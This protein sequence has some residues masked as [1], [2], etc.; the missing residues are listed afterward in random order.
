MEPF[1]EVAA[2]DRLVHEPARLAILSTLW[3]CDSADFLFV[4]RLTGLTKGNLSNHLARL[5]EA[6]LLDIDKKF[7]S[8]MPRTFLRLTDKGR[9]AIERHWQQ[10]DRLRQGVQQWKPEAENAKGALN[11]TLH[12]YPSK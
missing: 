9:I 4:Q 11:E 3:S 10:L 8:K 1:E 7:V 2:L 12:D 6:G 5:E